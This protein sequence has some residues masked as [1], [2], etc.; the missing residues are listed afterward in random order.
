LILL[1]DTHALIWA[2]EDSPLLSPTA[3]SVVQ[4]TTNT[5]LASVVSAWEISIKKSLGRLDAPDDLEDAVE[6]AGFTKRAIT[7]S[8]A[9][10]L[11]SLDDHHRDPFDRMLVAQA[12]EDGAPIVSR[13]PLIARYQVQIIW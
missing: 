5:V 9:R 12:L 6:A 3:R 13:D 2:L 4:D 8:D 10:R 11:G 1:L 7:F